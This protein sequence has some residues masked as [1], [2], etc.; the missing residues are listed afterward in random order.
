MIPKGHI[1]WNI[2]RTDSVYKAEGIPYLGATVTTWARI[3]LPML[4]GLA[5]L[6]PAPGASSSTLTQD[7]AKQIRHVSHHA[8]A[9][10]QTEDKLESGEHPQ[11]D[12]VH[13]L[14]AA[15]GPVA[16]LRLPPLVLGPN[17]LAPSP[18]D[19]RHSDQ[20]F[21]SHHTPRY[22]SDLYLTTLRL[23]I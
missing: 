13:H 7:V 22:S 18:Y 10:W 5:L 8:E 1:E 19:A 15:A 12:V 4:V 16:E 21:S 20:R 9:K 14:T 3:I 17:S 2:T 23:R 6:T 11:C